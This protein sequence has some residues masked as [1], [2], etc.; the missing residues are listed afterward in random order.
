MRNKLLRR[1]F[2]FIVAAYLIAVFALWSVCYVTIF[3]DVRRGR[4]DML[5][6]ISA[7][8]VDR[9]DGEFSRM[10]LATSTIAG[11]VY[12]RD[13]LTETDRNAYYEKAGAVSEIIR[14]TVYPHMGEDTVF[15]VGGNSYYRFTGSIS[16][17]AIERIYIE[18]AGGGNT[19]SIVTFEEATYFCMVSPV[20][21]SGG[22]TGD[23]AGYVV[24]LSN[25]AKVRRMLDT[26]D[27]VPGIDTA[28]ILD[29]EIL[30]SSNPELDGQ[31]ASELENR[32]GLV[33]VSGVTGSDLEAAAAITKDTLYSGERMLLTVA[34]ATLVVLAATVFVLYRVLSAQ[35]LSPT[36][37]EADTMRM[38]L[39]KTQMSSHFIVNT[40][41]CIEGLASAGDN[42]NAARA[43]ANLAGMLRSL[44]EAG[45]EENAYGQVGD[46]NRY[47]EIMNI[48]NN[49][50]YDVTIDV[51][52]KMCKYKMLGQVLQPLVE[53]AL[54][55]GF[56]DKENDC[57][58]TVT[59]E[60]NEDCLRFVVSD[61]GKGMEPQTARALQETLDGADQWDYDDYRLNG[62][63]L[64]NIQKRIRAKYGGGYGLTVQGAPG[65]GFA[66]TVTLPLIKDK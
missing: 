37:R 58:L 6:I 61:N 39:L 7:D 64:I 4:Q 44:H 22:G 52:D 31:S 27:T 65:N 33:T 29:G 30:F 14:K 38:G 66:V 57:R 62:V 18:I 55:H 13:F 8:L 16:N 5:T 2:A 32:Y 23:A 17:E 34:A 1:R 43:A 26:P 48:R 46:V 24:A 42:E 15:T 45:E 19:Y 36:M 54:T 60:V 9:L 28:V 40:I 47:I 3:R 35:V 41:A 25:L 11:S 53:N 12:V 10:K 63:A 49:G 59:G 51:T 21:A 50:R 56:A 20:Y